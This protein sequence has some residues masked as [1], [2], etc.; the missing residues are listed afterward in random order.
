MKHL[1][2]H[3]FPVEAFFDLSLVVTVAVPY[4]Q[5]L[6][7]IPPCLD[8]DVFENTW[9]FVA[10]AVVDTRALRPK[11]F[12]AWMG[13]NFLLAGY[14]I[15]TRFTTAE[16]KRLRGLY[17]LRS[18]TDKA[19]MTFLGSLFTRYRYVATDISIK[20][21]PDLVRVISDKSGLE[22]EAGLSL[23]PTLPAGSPFSSWKEARRYAGPLPF[24]FS[25]IPAMQKV[26]VIE[27]VRQHWE[28][29]PLQLGHFQS[30]I[31]QNMNLEGAMPASVFM[32]EQ[33]P[34]YWKKGKLM[35]WKKEA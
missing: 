10:L 1:Q 30:R 32:V 27:G 15:F 9:A 7:L 25:W 24:T 4:E 29:R 14:R 28:P 22:L 13:H 17:I 23:E 8:L 2:L 26:L 11:G 3:P 34:Y 33:V 6:P 16:G 12:P 5:L 18:E 20:K 21:T 19:S 31:I 35:S